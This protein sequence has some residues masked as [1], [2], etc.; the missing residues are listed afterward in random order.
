MKQAWARYLA[1]FA[2]LKDREQKII[3]AAVLVG[4]LFLGYT[5]AVEPALLEAQRQRKAGVEATAATA[6]LA[7]HAALLK[8]SNLD[9]D[10]ALRARRDQ[11]RGDLAKQGERFLAVEKSLV[12]A[13]KMAG[14]LESMVA[15]APNLQLIGM[16]TLA[17]EPVVAPK[18]MA[19]AE[20][21]SAS[22]GAKTESTAKEAA[23]SSLF[24]HGVE[25]R[26]LGGYHD[27]TAYIA[28]LE[29]A[30]QRLLWGKMDLATREWPRSQLTLTV[31]TLSLDRSW[32]ML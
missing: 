6:T 9:P 28:A 17:P 25:I 10:A 14:L 27:L 1:W 32:L 26:L 31:Y 4:G 18:P 7:R 24:R 30:P 29:A 8:Q 2:A 16:R 5:Y 15:R 3:A 11:L 13:S 19:G 22:G 12:P 21:E 20:A 23:R